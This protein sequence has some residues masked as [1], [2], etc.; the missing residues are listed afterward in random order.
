MEQ[1]Y[2]GS[3]VGHPSI[4]QAEWHDIICLSSPMS[5]ECCFGF[6]FFS[7]LIWL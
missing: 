2:H 5:G 3:L 1:G 7:I 6:V 4:L